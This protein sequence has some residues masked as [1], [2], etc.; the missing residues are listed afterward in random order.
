MASTGRLHP[1][2]RQSREGGW[3]DRLLEREPDS[4][5]RSLTQ[6]LD[7]VDEH[8]PP[9][10]DDGDLMGEPLDLVQ[11]VRG[12]EHGPPPVDYFSKK[13][14][15][16]LLEQGIE[17]GRGLVEDQQLRVVHERLYEADLL[18]VAR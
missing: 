6:A 17:P 1:D 11:V 3:V 4:S 16:L 2:H 14:R 5:R 10:P 18:P 15:E 9:L 8:Q 7:G 13:I 12:E